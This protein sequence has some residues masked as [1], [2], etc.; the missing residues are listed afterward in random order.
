MKISCTK[1]ELAEFIAVCAIN[2]NSY[3]C[4]SR[5]PL[6]PYC[7]GAYVDLVEEHFDVVE[8]VNKQ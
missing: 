5:C 3:S 4:N 8:G 2:N 1:A 7:K 6:E